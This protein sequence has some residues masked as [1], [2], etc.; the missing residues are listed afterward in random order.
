MCIQYA[1]KWEW[2]GNQDCPDNFYKCGDGIC[3]HNKESLQISHICPLTDIIET[4]S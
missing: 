2:V 3:I 1:K 4:S